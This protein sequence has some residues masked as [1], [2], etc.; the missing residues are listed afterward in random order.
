[1]TLVEAES[2]S[3]SMD[4]LSRSAWC[5]S[6]GWSTGSAAAPATPGGS[7]TSST[8][9]APRLL[10]LLGDISVVAGPI[11]MGVSMKPTDPDLGRI[12]VDSSSISSSADE[13]QVLLDRMDRPLL[14]LLDLSICCLARSQAMDCL[15]RAPTNTGKL[16]SMDCDLSIVMKSLLEPVNAK[17]INKAHPIGASMD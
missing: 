12:G 1:M 11:P 17:D 10:Y 2:F 6:Q 9:A 4:T 13:P 14:L 8:P 5:R 15:G 3:D 7:V 16:S